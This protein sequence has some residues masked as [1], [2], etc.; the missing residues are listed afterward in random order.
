MNNAGSMVKRARLAEFT[1][2][3]FDTVMTLNV[4]S[5][6]FI[7]QALAPR[8]VGG[9]G[10]VIV[11]VSSIAARNGGGLGATIYSAAKAAVATITKGMARNWRRKG[12]AS[13]RSAP[14]RW[15]T[16]FTRCSR[17]P[18]SWTACGPPRPPEGWA[19][20]KRWPI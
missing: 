15:T 19:P 2:E 17:R 4:K 10:G 16:I 9:G 18:K 20:M 14:E 6:W 1:P 3:L 13:T 12:F 7:S 11:N 8:M 5:L